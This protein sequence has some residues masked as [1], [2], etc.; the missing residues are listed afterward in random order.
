MNS[1]RWNRIMAEVGMPLTVFVYLSW[2]TTLFVPNTIA[3]AIV[4]ALAVIVTSN[5]VK[6]GCLT[7]AIGIIIFLFLRNY[8]VI[9]INLPFLKQ[10][11]CWLNQQSGAAG[12]AATL[13]VKLF[14]REY[15]KFKN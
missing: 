13:I 9:P 2:Y 7:S 8:F 11:F 10:P 5:D 12:F 14:L 4:Y 1:E 6:S 15:E 3:L